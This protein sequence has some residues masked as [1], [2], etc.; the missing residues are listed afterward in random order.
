MST[1]IPYF[2]EIA[3]NKYPEQDKRHSN[4]TTTLKTMVS[5]LR[6]MCKTNEYNV[7]TI[8]MG[9]LY[10]HIRPSIVILL[11]LFMEPSVRAQFD[12]YSSNQ[13][14]LEW[15]KMFFDN[16]MKYNVPDIAYWFFLKVPY[17]YRNNLDARRQLMSSMLDYMTE[18]WPSDKIFNEKSF[19]FTTMSSYPV[20]SLAYH[21]NSN[22]EILGKVCKLIRKICPF[23]NYR[24]P[25]ISNI[26]WKAGE[27]LKVCFVSESLSGDTSVLRDRIGIILNLPKEQFDV[28]YATFSNME[29]VKNRNPVAMSLYK[30]MK[31]RYIHLSNSMDDARKR[32]SSHNFHIIVYPDIGMKITQTFLAYSRIAPIQINTW[33]HSDTSGIDTV[34]YYITSKYFEVD[35]IAEMQ[36]HYSEKAIA[37]PS[38]GTYYY[39]PVSMFVKE[40]LKP[41][42][43][44]NLSPDDHV[45]WCMQTFYKFND[46][47]ENIIAQIIRSDDKAIVLLSVVIPFCR[48]HLARIINKIGKEN[49]NKIKFYPAKNKLDFY[50]L[51]KLSDVV[52]DPY[53]FGGCNSSLEAF[54]L[55]VPVV[56]MPSQFINGRFTYGF[57]QKMGIQDCLASTVD[58][59][60]ETALKLV[61]NY[62]FRNSVVA[63]INKNKNLLFED[64]ESVK[65]WTKCLLDLGEKHIR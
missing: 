63:K 24:N 30:K 15:H 39:S 4:L 54:D 41:R 49:A 32:L 40:D 50:S 5:N 55:G 42:E 46:E 14:N 8:G 7:F 36:S 44:Y 1:S 16:L 9:Y 65:D 37:L 47:F 21:N 18:K 27:K 11:S 51:I 12:K 28:Y 19:I 64:P 59:Y 25:N 35:D 3:R 17:F 45:Y 62:D 43:Y 29:L 56:S 23:V 2:W 48:S 60:V 38:F 53:P 31:D 13:F 57:Y 33:G 20:Y 34:D 52:L 58:E 22:K 10:E 26:R 61:N 6:R